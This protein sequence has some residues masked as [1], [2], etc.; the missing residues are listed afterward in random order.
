MC[1]S[2]PEV[3][4]PSNEESGLLQW[5][6]QKD[7]QDVE[8]LRAQLDGIL[9]ESIDDD[10]SIRLYPQKGSP[11]GFAGLA[12]VEGRYEDA[13]GI[14]VSL[15]IHLRNGFLHELEIYKDDSTFIALRPAEAPTL[16]YATARPLGWS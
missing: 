8:E 15:L 14:T 9:V 12:P 3:R 6:L 7:F 11:A 13:D 5:L 16:R 4:R 1:S 2:N 10:G